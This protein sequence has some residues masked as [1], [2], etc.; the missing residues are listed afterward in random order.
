MD[1]IKNS[2]EYI[3]KKRDSTSKLSLDRVRQLLSFLGNPQDKLKFIHIAGTN[4]KGSI[5]TTLS[6]ILVDAGYKVGKCI[7]PYVDNFYERIQI[8]N[9]YITEN[10]VKI[11]LK[12]MMPCIDSM[13]DA[14]TPFEILAAASFYYFY[15]NNCDIVC[16]EVGIGGRFDATNCIDTTIISVISVIDYDHMEYLGNTIE[17][18][19]FE[20]CGIIKENKV[21]I[22]Y[23]QQK[24]SALKMIKAMTDIR[25]NKLV[26]IDLKDLS[27]VEKIYF[28]YK[29]QYKNKEYVLGLNGKHQIYNTLVVIETINELNKL[30]Y[31]ISY[32]SLYVAIKNTRFIGRLDQISSRP[33]T[34]LDGAHNQSGAESLKQFIIEN[35][36]NRKIIL[37]IGMIEGKRHEEFFKILG[38]LAKNTIITEVKDKIKKTADVQALFKMAKKYNENVELEVS[39]KKAYMRAKELCNKNDIIIVTGSLYLISELYKIYKTK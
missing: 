27:K 6:N 30:G 12:K 31:D 17:E 33:I 3:F 38:G 26:L 37:L 21:T 34:I 20:K 18:I 32:S 11:I 7:S 9:A 4:G 10:D 14:P 36:E 15:K 22:S 2:F 39:H 25:K 35:K 13:E 19:A 23:P 5:T 8:D 29:F 1:N 16:L 24:P 28:N